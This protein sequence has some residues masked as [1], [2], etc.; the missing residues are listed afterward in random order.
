MFGIMQLSCMIVVQDVS[1]DFRVT[2]KEV[3]ASLFVEEKFAFGW[4]QERVGVFLERVSPRLEP[5]PRHID[6]HLLI[7]GLTSVLQYRGRG[8]GARCNGNPTDGSGP[9]KRQPGWETKKFSLFRESLGKLRQLTRCHR[10]HVWRNISFCGGKSRRNSIR[11]TASLRV[12]ALS[13]LAELF[14]QISNERK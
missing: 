6:E 5:P 8:K 7:L 3:L 9:R 13:T 14:L 2:I 4:A 10:S 11:A 1:E 12:F